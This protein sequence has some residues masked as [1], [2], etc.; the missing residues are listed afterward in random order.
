MRRPPCS[1]VFAAL[2]LSLPAILAADT[3]HVGPTGDYAQISDVTGL[4]GPG[5]LVLVD[6]G[7]TYN[8]V[9]FTNDGAPGR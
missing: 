5:D 8:P 9:L 7:A 6:G 4:V 2:V 3:F 1:L